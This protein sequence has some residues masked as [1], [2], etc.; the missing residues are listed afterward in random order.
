MDDT[1]ITG[2]KELSQLEYN[3]SIKSC[4]FHYQSRYYDVPNTCDKKLSMLLNLQMSDVLLQNKIEKLIEMRR[5]NLDAKVFFMF[6][7]FCII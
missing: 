4:S 5:F 3:A 1:S 2:V 6:S 7:Y